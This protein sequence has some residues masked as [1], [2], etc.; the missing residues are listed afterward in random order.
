MAVD[1]VLLAPITSNYAEFAHPTNQDF[2]LGT[3]Y[4]DSPTYNE[5]TGKYDVKNIY[6][7]DVEGNVINIGTLEDI[8]EEDRVNPSKVFWWIYRNAKGY[9]CPSC[10]NN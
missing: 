10:M 7:T 5:E 4:W 6:G 1:I 2:N 9:L 3:L 8:P